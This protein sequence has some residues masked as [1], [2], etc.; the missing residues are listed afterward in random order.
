MNDLIKSILAF[1]LTFHYVVSKIK[2][3]A[4]RPNEPNM[5]PPTNLDI[6]RRKFISRPK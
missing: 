2:A 3:S 6:I 1:P 4:I 5:I